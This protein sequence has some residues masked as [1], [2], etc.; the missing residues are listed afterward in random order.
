MIRCL[1]QFS[2]IEISKS[3]VDN[4]TMT[5]PQNFLASE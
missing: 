2:L 4:G 5:E 1:E 3:K